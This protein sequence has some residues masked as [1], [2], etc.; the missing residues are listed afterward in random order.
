MARL[1]R[2]GRDFSPGTRL[3]PYPTARGPIAALSP[4]LRPR[5]ILHRSRRGTP[6]NGCSHLERD[7]GSDEA[8]GYRF[9]GMA[10]S[11]GGLGETSGFKARP[12]GV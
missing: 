2:I 9:D 6:Q 8:Q 12:A 7:V 1:E 4:N 3:S 5:A 10:P 11:P